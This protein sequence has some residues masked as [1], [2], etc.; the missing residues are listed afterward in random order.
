MYHQFFAFNRFATRSRAVSTALNQTFTALVYGHLRPWFMAINGGLHKKSH[1]NNDTAVYGYGRINSPRPEIYCSGLWQST[2]E[3]FIGIIY[4]Y[5]LFIR[6]T[7]DL[8]YYKR[9]VGRLFTALV[10]K[11]LKIQFFCIFHDFG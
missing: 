10:V 2:W 7:A 9:A 1:W 5:G 11:R 8:V 4:G 6:R 3:G